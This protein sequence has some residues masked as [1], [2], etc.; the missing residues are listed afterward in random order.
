[1]EKVRCGS[2]L[3]S[4]GHELPVN[5]K[6]IKS[7]DNRDVYVSAIIENDV[8]IRY[9]DTGEWKTINYELIKPYL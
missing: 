6:L 9:L 4:S 3:H 2:Y 5:V 7:K 1:M 8:R